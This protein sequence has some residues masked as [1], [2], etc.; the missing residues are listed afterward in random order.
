MQS[1]TSEESFRLV[2]HICS[3]YFSVFFTPVG[4]YRSGLGARE[5]GLFCFDVL[6]VLNKVS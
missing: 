4:F 3:G 1:S 5:I 2:L 6:G